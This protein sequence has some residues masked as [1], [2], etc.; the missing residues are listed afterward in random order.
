[1]VKN[2][3]FKMFLVSSLMLFLIFNSVGNVEANTS[4][5]E[6]VNE[7]T[8]EIIKNIKTGESIIA[9]KQMKLLKVFNLGNH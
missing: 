2:N 4:N 7:H 9:F 3:L 1:M 6:S 5:I 8:E